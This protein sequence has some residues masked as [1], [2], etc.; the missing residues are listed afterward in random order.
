MDLVRLAA[1]TD[2]RAISGIYA[3]GIAAGTATVVRRPPDEQA[4]RA[5]IE[6][7]LPHHRWRVAEST[8]GEV[9]GWAAT[10]PYAAPEE[11]AGVAEFSVYV[12][13][14]ARGR[15][16]GRAL[17]SALLAAAERDGLHKLTSRVFAAN[18]AS[19]SLLAAVGFREVGTHRRH[20]QVDG[21]WR[22]VVVVEALVGPARSD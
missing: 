1:P 8:D 14:A 19:R 16:V 11:Y 21:R 15:G 2:A 7:C 22:D 12:A 3:E 6:A 10:M 17:M 9:V 20:V 13:T 18:A 5:R 4:V